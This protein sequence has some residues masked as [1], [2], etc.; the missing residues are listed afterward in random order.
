MRKRIDRT[1]VSDRGNIALII[2]L[3]I[4]ATAVYV[5]SMVAIVAEG[6]RNRKEHRPT[7]VFKIV[8]AG[9]A[10][11]PQVAE[12]IGRRLVESDCR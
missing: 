10:V 7:P 6:N 3:A 2:V 12:W 5:A 8:R 4:M 9:H 1:S 11:V